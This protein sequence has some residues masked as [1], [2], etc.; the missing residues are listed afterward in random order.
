MRVP[1]LLSLALAFFT[2]C[3]S[4]PPA[5]PTPPPGESARRDFWREKVQGVFACRN[6]EALGEFLNRIRTLPPRR[7]ANLGGGGYQIGDAPMVYDELYSLD[8][9]F[10]L[11]LIWNGKDQE[12]GVRSVEV[13]SFADLRPGIKPEYFNALQAL[14]RCPSAM[15]YWSFDPVLVVRAVNAFWAMGAQA[16]PALRAYLD[17]AR[18]LPLE[19]ARKYSVDEF[20][21]FPVVQLLGKRPSPFL[22]GNGGVADPGPD[23]WPQFPLTLEQDIPFMVVSGYS[24]GGKPEDIA[25]RL[26]PDFTLRAGPLIP[27]GNPVELLE[28]LVSSQRWE[29]LLSAESIGIMK[30][31]AGGAKRLRLLVRSQALEALAPVYRPPQDFYPKNCCEDPSEAEWRRVVEEVRALGIHWNAQLQEFVRSR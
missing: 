23:S 26:G 3:G 6:R 30:Q 4:L 12:Q 1:H 15:N 7:P 14:N 24:L 13:V 28:T 9:T 16:A 27:G 2:G 25:G 22:L 10:D 21:L 11:Y 8:E 5:P 18:R 17:L 29:S 20:R 19:E 31:D